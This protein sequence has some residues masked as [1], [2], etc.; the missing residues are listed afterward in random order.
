MPKHKAKSKTAKAAA[1]KKRAAAEEKPKGS[2]RRFRDAREFVDAVFAMSDGVEA[3]SKLLGK[4]RFLEKLI[5]LRFGKAPATMEPV[6]PLPR[7]VIDMPGPDR[8]S[9]EE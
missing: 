4:D 1:S 7:I 5:E 3:A 8:E 9:E 6:M 2:R